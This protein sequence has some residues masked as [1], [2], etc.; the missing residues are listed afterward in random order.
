[1]KLQSFSLISAIAIALAMP[2]MAQQSTDL[3]PDFSGVWAQLALGGFDAPLSGPGPVTNRS[4]RNG[5]S[6]L[7][8]KR[9][10]DYTN[11]ILK[12]QAAEVVRKHGEISLSGVTYATPSNQCWPNGV[13]YVFWNTGPADSRRA[14]S[15]SVPVVLWSSFRSCCS[16]PNSMSPKVFRWLPKSPRL[17]WPE[18]KDIGNGAAAVRRARPS[19]MKPP[20]RK[21]CLGRPC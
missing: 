5:V 19:K 21:I 12:P 14:C 20:Q 4:R 13:P 10:G 8:G 7:F 6:D 17:A 15:A 2:A 3:R 18:S 11:P 16:E 1:M 9:V